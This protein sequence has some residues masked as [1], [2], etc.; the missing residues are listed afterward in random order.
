MYKLA[1]FAAFAA[2]ALAPSLVP[3]TAE[4]RTKVTVSPTY[5]PAI[6][7][8]YKS[9]DWKTKGIVTCPTGWQ[10]L[11][12]LGAKWKVSKTLTNCWSTNGF[13]GKE[14]TGYWSKCK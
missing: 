4:A 12:E 3:S 11:G 13:G 6:Y 14:Y 5:V 10:P 7:C 2:F 1:F 9:K 8:D